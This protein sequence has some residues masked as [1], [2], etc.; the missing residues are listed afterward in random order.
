MCSEMGKITLLTWNQPTIYS[1]NVRFSFWVLWWTKLYNSDEH[2]KG[3]LVIFGRK[4]GNTL[5]SK[6]SLRDLSS[7]YEWT[8]KQEFLVCNQS[9]EIQRHLWCGS[10]VG[11]QNVLFCHPTWPP[12]HCL[13]GSPGIGCKP[14]IPVFPGI[15]IN[16]FIVNWKWECIM[17]SMLSVS[18]LQ[19]D[20]F[21]GRP[22]V[23]LSCPQ[24]HFRVF[25]YS[26]GN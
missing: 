16:F 15:S 23:A 19:F 7:I 11:W 1:Q 17:K 22:S 3:K 25:T 18:V 6:S 5:F 4:L 2:I 10:H 14:R 21:Q 9:L 13:F 12:C 8:G 26:E 24:H 20:L